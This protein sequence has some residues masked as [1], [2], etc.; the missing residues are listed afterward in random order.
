MADNIM[1]NHIDKSVIR[2]FL[3]VFLI[4]VSVLAYRVTEY[5]PCKQVDFEIASDSYIEGTLIEFKDF[6]TNAT[7]W[8]WDFGDGTKVETN[9]EILHSFKKPGE[10]NVT[11][12]IN[13]ICEDIKQVVIKE[14]PFVLDPTKLAVFSLPETIKVGET[15]K[16]KDETPNAQTWEWRFG[17]T[18]KLNSEES[19]A[20]YVYESGGLKTVTLVVNGDVKHA[21]SKQ[22]NVIEPKKEKI[23]DAPDDVSSGK[24]GPSK[25]KTVPNITESQFKNNLNLVAKKK[26]TPDAFKEYFCGDLDKAIIVNG[27]KTTFLALCELLKSKKVKIRDVKLYKDTNNCINNITITR[28]KYL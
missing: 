7:A 13:G 22:I 26:M 14:K 5:T 1:S 25:P 3:I 24:E 28:T 12:K 6:T 8:E 18:A 17:E 20:E 15:L 23:K 21:T 11:L 19:R 16:V 2:L 9:R 4:S 27:E 10:Y